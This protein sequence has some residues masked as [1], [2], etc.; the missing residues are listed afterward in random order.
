MITETDIKNALA[1]L[2]DETLLSI[3]P[4]S[5]AKHA[6]I[7][8]ITMV[9]GDNYVA[10]RATPGLKDEAAQLSVLSEKGGLPVPKIHKIDDELL[11]MD[12]I[13]SDWQMDDSAQKDAAVHLARLHQTE[14]KSYGYDHNTMIAGIPQKNDYHDDWATFFVENRLMYM[15]ER[16]RQ[17]GSLDKDTFKDIEKLTVKVPQIIG[18]GNPPALIHGDCWGGNILSHRGKIAAFVDPAIYY[19]DPEIELA[20]GTLFNTFDQNFFAR[21]GKEIEIKPGFFEERRDLYNLYPLL[22]HTELFGRSYVRKIKRILKK[23][24]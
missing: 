2:F 22:V 20:F 23:F 6:E 17:I 10:K 5:A 24:D 21:Y 9:N 13:V 12:Y 3:A 18:T 4:L 16:T 1:E 14:G 11:I 15:A 8:R 19:A 7:F